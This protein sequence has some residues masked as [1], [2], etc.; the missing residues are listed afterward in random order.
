LFRASDR[1]GD[2]FSAD[3]L[4]LDQIGRH[5]FYGF[6]AR[7][8]D[9]LFPDEAFARWFCPDNGRPCTSPCLLTKVLVL[10]MYTG[11]SDE[12]AVNRARWDARWAAALGTRIGEQPFAKSTLQLHRARLHLSK[13]GQRLLEITVQEARRAGILK[14]KK[15]KVALDTTPVFGRGALK[16]TYNLVGDG[17]RAVV[18][19]LARASGERPQ[20]WAARHDLSRYWQGSLKGQA[21]ID[22][23]QEKERRAFLGALVADVNRVLVFAD[24][25]LAQ[26]SPEDP[27]A[28]AIRRA[29]D[30]LRQ[31]VEQ[32]VDQ[33]SEEPR[34]KE[35]VAR[36]RV[37]SVTDPE[38]RHGHKSASRRF[39][40]YKMALAVEPVSQII[41]ALKTL[42]ANAPDSQDALELVK[43]SEKTTAAVVEKAIGDCAYGDGA[44]RST[45][46]QENRI[47]VARVPSPPKD[48]PCHKAHFQI[49]LVNRR[50]TCPAGHTTTDFRY[51]TV[52]R[53]ARTRGP[54]PAVGRFRFPAELC[55]ACPLA[56]RCLQKKN[57]GGGRV[58][59]L[60]P[61]ER[62]LQ[63]ARA[64]QRTE[65]FRQDQLDR[66]AV[67]HRIARLC[68]LGLRQ[69]RYFGRAKT[70]LQGILAAVVANLTRILGVL[71]RQA[72]AV[73]MSAQRL[74]LLA[75]RSLLDALTPRR[76]QTRFLSLP[77]RAE[78]VLL[79]R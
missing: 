32:D 36:D 1:Q 8:G 52:R 71:T 29:S 3:N 45:F 51:V 13:M 4:Y 26:R 50:V 43:A 44:T 77:G 6:L 42:P 14:G 60:H 57:K 19:E 61:Q 74:F 53:S 20:Q 27:Q 68:Q 28:R 17:I 7:E 18:G 76:L 79:G 46:A 15:I 65:A 35:G 73:A 5:T 37:L 21:D 58:V 10:Q 41:T 9:R 23:S 39:D 33:S 62:L 25:A 30:L 11:C 49:D 75:L 24:R 64:Y 22:W 56:S 55:R 38:M 69:S 47:L 2:L 34:L 48:E 66:Q 12:E 67:E 54:R 78:S 31:L 70:E 40:G 72:P 59:T 16:D 63:E